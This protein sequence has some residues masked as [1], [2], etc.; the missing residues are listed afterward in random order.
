MGRNKTAIIGLGNY[1]LGDEG[2]GMHAVELLREK[3]NGQNVD[4]V[5]AGT[6]GMNL[7]HQFE[8]REKVIFIDAGNLGLMPGE[9]KRFTY[10]QVRSLKKNKGY[11]LHEFDLI[12][13]LEQATAL[14][15][16][17]GIDIVIYG[18]QVSEIIMSEQLSDIV[19][20]TLEPLVVDVYNEALLKKKEL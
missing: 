15:K 12:S 5:D 19:Q 9:Y 1:L 17:D 2:A 8:E 4:I 20:R 18:I 6:P 3:M 10:N 16:T 7:L 14:K 11:S 13:F